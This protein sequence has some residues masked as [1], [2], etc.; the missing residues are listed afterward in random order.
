LLSYSIFS[1]WRPK[2]SGRRDLNPRPLAPQA[3]GDASEGIQEL[4]VTSTL[5]LACTAACTSGWENGQNRG[6]TADPIDADLARL[7]EVWP[8]LPE[9][10]RR[11]ILSLVESVERLDR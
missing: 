7:I 2:K 4:E 3:T 10:I 1:A 5:P 11:A 9:A 6:E 8:T